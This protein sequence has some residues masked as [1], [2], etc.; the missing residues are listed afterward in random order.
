MKKAQ[1]IPFPTS[2]AVQPPNQIETGSANERTKSTNRVEQSTAT[3]WM[4]GSLWNR[5]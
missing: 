2:Q 5:K 1:S 3:I 4:I